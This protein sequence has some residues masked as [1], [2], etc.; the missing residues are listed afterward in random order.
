MG[1]SGGVLICQNGPRL[2]NFLFT[3]D[4]LFSCRTMENECQD[5]LDV[6]VI[7]EGGFE[8]KD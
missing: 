2:T 5:M 8:S 3:N 1:T 7:Y 6:L 4:S